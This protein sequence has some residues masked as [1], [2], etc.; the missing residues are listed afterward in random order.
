MLKGRQDPDVAMQ[1]LYVFYRERDLI[2]AG[3]IGEQP[4]RSIRSG[5]PFNQSGSAKSAQFAF[6]DL[7]LANPA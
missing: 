2:G 6:V 1:L 5:F 3:Y 7:N 4:E